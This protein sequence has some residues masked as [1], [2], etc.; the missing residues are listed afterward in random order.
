MRES[1]HLGLSTLAWTRMTREQQHRVRRV[2]IA[3]AELAR[4]QALHE[5]LRQLLRPVWHAACVLWR[6]AAKAIAR[7]RA[8]RELR[9]FD[10]LSLRD[11][12]LGRSEIEAAVRGDLSRDRGQANKG[13]T[14]DDPSASSKTL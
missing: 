12:G 14:H 1:R 7:R 13:A 4:A 6:A 2:I 3:Q 5:L 10:D 9:A 11:I 8:M